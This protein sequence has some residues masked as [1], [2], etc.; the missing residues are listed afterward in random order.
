MS[1][2]GADHWVL[3]YIKEPGYF[4]DIGCADGQHISNT[5]LLEQNGWNGLCIDAFPRNFQN[6]P[7]SIVETAVLF[8]E[9]DIEVDFVVPKFDPDFA[10]ITEHLGRHKDAVLNDVESHIIFR[11]SL[12]EEILVKHNCPSFIQYVNLDIE[13]SE[14]E[15]LRTFDFTK[16]S[17]GLLTVEHNFD[18][19]KRTQ[20]RALLEEKGYIYCKEV[21]FDD[22]YYNKSYS[23][24]FS[25]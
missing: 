25:G 18:E 23:S 2:L 3:S 14:Y 17:F 6:R 11:T 24:L 20:I 8:S 16:Y 21:N 22:W 10:G 4:L 9:K 12:L 13:G 19:P 7:N 1:Q 15:V 5:Y